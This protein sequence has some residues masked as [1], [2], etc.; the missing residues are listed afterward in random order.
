MSAA[1]ASSAATAAAVGQTAA[2]D[3]PFD[4]DTLVD[5]DDDGGGDG[6][7]D[8][9]DANASAADG[10]PAS[11]A[12]LSTLTSA[13]FP[14]FVSLRRFLRM[15][16]ASTPTP[17][18]A[19]KRAGSHCSFEFFRQV[20]APTVHAHGLHA[21]VMWREIVSF[22]KGSARALDSVD[23]A[24]SRDDY[25]LQGRKRSLVHSVATREQIYGAYELYERRKQ[26]HGCWDDCDLVFA[27]WKS[28]KSVGYLGQPIHSLVCD[29]VQ[30]FS[31]ATLRLLLACCHMPD[32]YFMCGDT[33]QTIQDGIDFRFSDLRTL[34]YRRSYGAPTIHQLTVNFRSH[35]QL[36]RLGNS[37]VSLIES[38]FPFTIDRLEK[39]QG[40]RQG[41]LPILFDASTNDEL[42]E[43]LFGGQQAAAGAGAG[44]IQFGAS[45]VIIVRDERARDALPDILKHALVLTIYECKGLEFDDVLLYNFFTDSLAPCSHWQVLNAFVDDEQHDAASTAKE[46]DDEQ[47]NADANE[48]EARMR[49]RRQ[50]NE[51]DGGLVQVDFESMTRSAL[52]ARDGTSSREARLIAHKLTREVDFDVARHSL[53]C[54][55]LKRLYT[56]ATRPKQ[57]LFVFDESIEKRSPAFNYWMSKRV[58]QV[59]SPGSVSSRIVRATPPSAWR[60]QG[61]AMLKRK[62]YAQAIKC[63]EHAGDAQLKAASSAA[64]MSTD[65]AAMRYDSSA[66]A[67]HRASTLYRASADVFARIDMPRR[68][69]R[70]LE[71]AG[72][73]AGAAELYMRVGLAS[74]AARCYMVLGRHEDAADLFVLLRCYTD[75]CAQLRLAHRYDRCVEVHLLGP[76]TAHRLRAGATLP[77]QIAADVR[78]FVQHTGAAVN[79]T[80][81][82]AEL[83]W[84]ADTV[85][86]L[87]QGVLSA[88]APADDALPDLT[89]CVRGS[90]ADGRRL[91][92]AHIEL[93]ERTGFLELVLR[94][95][96]ADGGV[97]ARASLDALRDDIINRLVHSAASNARASATDSALMRTLLDIVEPSAAV[98]VCLTY[99]MWTRGAETLAARAADSQLCFDTLV[100]LHAAKCQS[101]DIEHLAAVRMAPTSAH[102]LPH[103]FRALPAEAVSASSSGKSKR[104]AKPIVSYKKAAQLTFGSRVPMERGRFDRMRALA[105]SDAE[106]LTLDVLQLCA[107]SS[108]SAQRFDLLAA[109]LLRGGHDVLAMLALRQLCRLAAANRERRAS[110]TKSK[111]SPPLPAALALRG[112]L[113]LIRVVRR[114]L[115]KLQRLLSRTTAS[116][117]SA[118]D[119]AQLDLLASLVGMVRVP[120]TPYCAGGMQYVVPRNSLIECATIY[121][122]ELSQ[123]QDRSALINLGFALSGTVLGQPAHIAFGTLAVM[124][125]ADC[126]TLAGATVASRRNIDQ[127]HAAAARLMMRQVY[128][129]PLFDEREPL[130]A[131]FSVS[132]TIAT[133]RFEW[134][135]GERA[136]AA[137]G[138][139]DARAR[140]RRRS[141]RAAE[142]ARSSV[143][144]MVPKLATYSAPYDRALQNAGGLCV[145]VQ[146]LVSASSPSVLRNAYFG[147]ALGCF[148]A[149]AQRAGNASLHVPSMWLR[150]ASLLELGAGAAGMP[151]V[152]S[153]LLQRSVQ[154]G[155]SVEVA[156]HAMLLADI[157][158]AV[159]RADLFEA[160]QLAV[161]YLVE[162]RACAYAERLGFG[163]RITFAE[164]F[165]AFL[166]PHMPPVRGS[167]VRM[168][169]WLFKAHLKPFDELEGARVHQLSP[170]IQQAGPDPIWY[171]GCELVETLLFDLV[172]LAH[173]DDD[174]A[175]LND[176]VNA[177]SL[178]VLFEFN[179]GVVAD[180]AHLT[181]LFCAA[182][183]GVGGGDDDDNGQQD[184]RRR[185]YSRR[186]PPAVRVA[187]RLA[188]ALSSNSAPSFSEGALGRSDLVSVLPCAFVQQR[189][190]GGTAGATAA[191]SFAPPSTPERAAHRAAAV[192]QRAWRER[193]AERRSRTRQQA[194]TTLG[195]WWRKMSASRRSGPSLLGDHERDKLAPPTFGGFFDNMPTIMTHFGRSSS[196]ATLTA[197]AFANTLRALLFDRALLRSV[198]GDASVRTRYVSLK[199]DLAPLLALVGRLAAFNVRLMHFVQSKS[200]GGADAASVHSMLAHCTML[201]EH[202]ILDL[203]DV[204]D[205]FYAQ[206]PS[207]FS[208]SKLSRHCRLSFFVSELTIADYDND[209]DNEEGDSS[210]DDDDHRPMAAS[211]SFGASPS[212]SSLSTE[213][214]GDVPIDFS[215]TAL[216]ERLDWS[217][218]RS[219][220]DESSSQFNDMR[221]AYYSGVHKMGPAQLHWSTKLHRMK[222][223][224]K[225]RR[226]QERR[227]EAATREKKARRV[228]KRK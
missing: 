125:V 201:S 39:D 10:S 136:V 42:F 179:T 57:R 86:P 214:S 116:L 112:A 61:I 105:A 78:Q 101:V 49:R 108:T 224:A 1:A 163:E 135:Q 64:Q 138:A 143:A 8:E 9:G 79:R 70:A 54:A 157:A 206:Q 47:N 208:E 63:F 104:A 178:L 115:A 20:V 113:N 162:D 218:L 216:R 153:E 134:E 166:M 53:L 100:A 35:A 90:A 60:A 151:D 174:P 222:R 83:A 122:R 52:E 148:A 77:T 114:V 124:L 160:S 13:D 87:A 32:S 103:V 36:I 96:R 227:Q 133:R 56:A 95:L 220:I 196:G 51:R 213:D 210:D 27:L 73:H 55:E 187:R 82:D 92:V 221:S 184:R 65:A 192:I 139:V 119:V 81:A 172:D 106:R 141:L 34:L 23:G 182:A 132:A 189:V 26:A 68:A 58:V 170:N 98:N 169:L 84:L 121:M 48:Q 181:E 168:P 18:L 186:T 7:D 85:A 14:L 75:A 80:D 43:L 5:D 127:V 225:N 144:H 45:Q 188:A 146:H 29:E 30:D 202:T 31:Q 126:Q 207:A 159:A 158:T 99:G 142:K 25:T 167:V 129:A 147:E 131:R 76:S 123:Q 71:A 175:L 165:L 173:C 200:I 176:I 66:A 41:E 204:V 4:F 199:R 94:L 215:A 140:D 107:L 197:R 128:M 228:R 161:R 152:L 110:G 6:G 171:V 198:V 2:E 46:G 28:V 93:L 155:G 154:L 164:R 111:A 156:K 120:G 205:A 67:R 149:M 72:Q 69:A 89:R 117:L 211:S 37:V 185:Q 137:L 15:L 74:S 59:R 97:P 145:E 191:P 219:F 226:Q 11:T 109:E 209:D 3:E 17:F 193:A 180:S 33:A 183:H 217:M 118:D 194:A 102:T 44:D 91:T 212:S 40:S 130:L 88:A 38:L 19:A 190:P 150:I 195:R 16:D 223:R 24:L 177:L 22:I 50:R 203:F 62:F 12:S 21:S